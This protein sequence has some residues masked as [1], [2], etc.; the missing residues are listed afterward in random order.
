MAAQKSGK[1]GGLIRGGSKFLGVS[2][3]GVSMVFLCFCDVTRC[4]LD[5]SGTF[6]GFSQGLIDGFVEFVLGFSGTFR[7]FLDGAMGLCFG[8]LLAA[9][10]KLMV[11]EPPTTGAISGGLKVFKSLL[12]APVGGSGYEVFGLMSYLIK[13]KTNPRHPQ[14]LTPRRAWQKRSR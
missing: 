6:L 11:L 4:F 9:S 3:L 7:G 1:I 5:N 10:P 13:S 12:K 14:T 8:R 2:F